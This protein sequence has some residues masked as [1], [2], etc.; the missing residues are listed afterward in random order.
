MTDDWSDETTAKLVQIWNERGHAG[1]GAHN[2]NVLPGSKAAT[3]QSWAGEWAIAAKEQLGLVV[4][5]VV[6]NASDP[7]DAVATIAGQFVSVELAEFVDGG[8][9]SGLKMYRQ[10]PE[11]SGKRPTSYNDPFFTAAQWTQDRFIKELNRLL[12][13]KHAKYVKRELVFDYLVV[14]SAEP[15]LF[16]RDVADWLLRNPIARRESLRCVHFLMDYQPG[17]PGRHPVFHVY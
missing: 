13:G 1:A 17:R 5:D 11:H 7:P 16:P 9:I 2:D 4:E 8:L 10:K 3:E 15:R 6:M 14:F 12:D